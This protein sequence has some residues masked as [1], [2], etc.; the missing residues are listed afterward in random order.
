MH[1]H[2]HNVV[3]SRLSFTLNLSVFWKYKKDIKF[4]YFTLKKK[5]IEEKTNII[6]YIK[7]AG[8]NLILPQL[9]LFL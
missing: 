1:L 4:F 5:F 2:I 3:I 8:N 9:I 7:D 6:K